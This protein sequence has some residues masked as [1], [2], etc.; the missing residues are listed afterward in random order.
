MVGRW[1]AQ[2]GDEQGSHADTAPMGIKNMAKKRAPMLVVAV[3]MAFPTAATSI[4]QMMCIERSFVLDDVHVT[5][6]DKRNVANCLDLV[7]NA[8]PRFLSLFLF[9]STLHVRD[10]LHT[11][12]GAVSHSVSMLPYPSVPMMAGKKYWNVWLSRLMCWISMKR[13]SR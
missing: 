5:S 13:Y 10:D 12:T 8:I 6:M 2:R 1:R 3:A 7:S 11:Q 9:P 4:R